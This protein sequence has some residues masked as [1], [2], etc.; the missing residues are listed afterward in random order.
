MKTLH[1]LIEMVGGR[2]ASKQD[3]ETERDIIN[4][5]MGIRLQQLAQFHAVHFVVN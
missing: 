4:Y 2:V 5:K 1:Y 3:G